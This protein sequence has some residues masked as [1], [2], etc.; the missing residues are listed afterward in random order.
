MTLNRAFLVFW[1][2]LASGCL[3]S[4]RLPENLR[5]GTDRWIFLGVAACLVAFAAFRPFGVGLDDLNGYAT[6]QYEMS[7]PTL[8][9]GRIIQGSRDYAWYS[10]VGLL[11]SFYTGAR[12]VLWLS[13]IGLVL[14]LWILDRLCRYRTLALL[15]YFSTF[16]IIHDLTALRI[17]L[18]ISVYLL[19]F[20]FLVQGRTLWG[21]GL[22]LGNVFFHLQGILAP[23]LLAGRG[24]DLSPVRLRFFLLLPLLLLGVALYPNNEILNELLDHPAGRSVADLLFGSSYVEWKLGGRYENYRLLPVVVPPTLL[25]IAWL[26]PDLSKHSPVLL[27]FS[28]TSLLIAAWFLWGYAVIPDV[29][30]RVWHFFLVPIVFVIG[31]IELTRWKV[32]AILV[33]SGIYL[34]KYTVVNDLLLDQRHVRVENTLGGEVKIANLGIVQGIECG[35]DCGMSYT[36]GTK[37]VLSAKPEKGYV[38]DHWLSGC[39]GGVPICHMVVNEDTVV[40]AAFVPARTLSLNLKGQGKVSMKVDGQVVPCQ[41]PCQ[42]AVHQSARVELL[43]QPAEGFRW[44]NWS[45][46]CRGQNEVCSWLM[47]GFQSV[48]I[49]FIRVINVTVTEPIG[50]RIVWEDD[51]DKAC[52]GV[53][54]R[55]MDEGEAVRLKALPNPGFRFAGWTSGC[56]GQQIDCTLFPSITTQVSGRFVPIVGFKIEVSGSGQVPAGGM[57]PITLR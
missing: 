53:C 42:L 2:I 55:T 32:A 33:L 16:Y 50:G 27:R 46:P 52:P 21:G 10:I 30:L 1:V 35:K 36:E 8:E 39:Q 57:S 44:K 41:L 29:Q 22:L 24:I 47:N 14:K 15:I 34:L 5:I 6:L 48:E 9:C 40:S 4:L 38:F 23:L 12:V 43:A 17:S 3:I 45:G 13:G 26:L 19:G 28:A 18:A 11:K 25:I 56:K 54:S 31:N 20:Y 37:I 7:C 51:P 49:E